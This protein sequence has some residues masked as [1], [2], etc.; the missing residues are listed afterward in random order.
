MKVVDFF[1]GCGGTS[2]GFRN[3]GCT[4]V[5]AIDN[6]RDAADTFALNFPEAKVFDNDIRD[7]E[8][9]VLQP[10]LECNSE[11]LL[12]SACAPCQPFSKQ[13]RQP[14]KKD[15]RI[16]LLDEFSRFVRFYLPDFIF[17]ENVPGIQ[18]KFRGDGP[19]DCFLQ[20]LKELGYPGPCIKII[21][22]SHYGVPQLRP[23]LML[24]ASK[25]ASSTFPPA[26]HGGGHGQKPYSTVREWIQDLPPLS[27]GGQ[28]P[29]DA[30]HQAS[31]L[32]RMNLARIRNTPEGGDRRSWPKNLQLNCHRNM[33]EVSGREG[34]MDVYGRLAFDKPASCL[35]TRCISY[36][37]GRF[38]HPVQDRAISVREAACL[39]TFPRSFR[40]KGSLNSKARQIGNAVPPLLAEQI[41]LHLL[42]KK[43]PS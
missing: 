6:D 16:N 15:C 35:T 39:Q 1:S 24:I 42:Q 28:D 18:R 17:I 34:H 22:A 11:P 26:T 33:L 40:L 4:I 27:A 31:K 19:L 2:C 10:L 41:A 37:N 12:F 29:N 13:N 3:A 8:T 21:A 36:S 43:K 20:T 9:A 32:S 14:K 38:G 5:A 7:L 25:L 30:E 23:R